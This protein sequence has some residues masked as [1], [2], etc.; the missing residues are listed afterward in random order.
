MTPIIHI[1]SYSTDQ[2]YLDKVFYSNFYRLKKI[3]SDQQPESEASVIDIGAHCGYFTLTAIAAGYSRCYAFEPFAE[4]YRM[5]SKNIEIFSDSVSTFQL[6]AYHQNKYTYLKSPELNHNQFLDYGVIKEQQTPND[7]FS[8]FISISDIIKNVVSN[9]SVS[10][11]KINTGYPFDFITN[12]ELAFSSIKSI[13]F[14][15]PY[16][17]AEIKYIKQKL[18]DLG[19]KDSLIIELKDKEQEFGFLGFFSKDE[20]ENTFDIKDLREKNYENS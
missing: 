9:S 13:C 3:N 12:N 10:L 5:L 16:D 18:Q 2:Y 20:L 1:R 8:S 15:M 19:Y 6:G 7:S 17:K 14:E 11:L 4:N